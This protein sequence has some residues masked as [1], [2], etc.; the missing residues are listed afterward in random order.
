MSAILSLGVLGAWSSSHRVM[1]YVMR[2]LPHRDAD[3]I[4]HARSQSH[5]I[6]ATPIV[7]R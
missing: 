4:S 1:A 2:P 7:T 5:P 6:V 3:W